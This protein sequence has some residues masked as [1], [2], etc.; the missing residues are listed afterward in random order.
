MEDS[1]FFFYFFFFL[2]AWK[3][4]KVSFPPMFYT[5]IH[6]LPKDFIMTCV[7][8]FVQIFLCLVHKSLPNF[9]FTLLLYNPFHIV[10]YL[11]NIAWNCSSLYYTSLLVFNIICIFRCTIHTFLS[12]YVFNTKGY[13]IRIHDL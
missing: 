6:I 11:Y 3:R 13:Y 4:K 12:W 2:L 1:Q 5:S 8:D 9:C 10:I 7:T